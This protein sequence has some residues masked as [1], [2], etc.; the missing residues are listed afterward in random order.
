MHLELSDVAGIRKTKNL[1][2]N[3]AEN[4]QT[5]EEEMVVSMPDAQP[6]PVRPGGHPKIMVLLEIVEPDFSQ[7]ERHFKVNL[8]R[9]RHFE[10]TVNIR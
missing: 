10:E 8:N 3:E 5:P 1:T 6:C 4:L 7:N 9:K 2:R